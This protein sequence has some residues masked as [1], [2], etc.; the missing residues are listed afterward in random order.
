[1]KGIGI[2]LLSLA[3]SQS[4]TAQQQAASNGLHD[5]RPPV[6]IGNGLTWLWWTLGGVAA[7]VLVA[8]SLWQWWRHRKVKGEPKEEPV[9]PY[10]AALRQL[11]DVW[12]RIEEPKVFCT[13]LS[14]IVRHYLQG[15]FQLRAPERTTEEFLPELTGTA[16]LTENQKERLHHFLSQCDLVKFAGY[17]PS[18]EELT[19]LYNTAGELIEESYFSQV[20]A[21]QGPTS[22]SDQPSTVSLARQ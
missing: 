1:M 4:A 13:A 7:A 18:M 14:D 11:R 10:G 5:I 16:A 17:R 21:Q 19:A 22:S 20:E 6:P 15:Q 3:S 8:L 9:S 2:A 12:E